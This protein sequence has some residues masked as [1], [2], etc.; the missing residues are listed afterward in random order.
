MKFGFW[1]GPILIS[2]ALA[3]ELIGWINSDIGNQLR[4]L[5]LILLAVGFLLWLTKIIVDNFEFYIGTEFN[6]IDRGDI[7]KVIKIAKKELK[8]SP[9]RNEIKSI[10]DIRN[11]IIVTQKRVYKFFGFKKKRVTGFYS[12]FPLKAEVPSLLDKEQISVRQFTNDHIASRNQR[13]ISLYLGGVA[14]KGFGFSIINCLKGVI[15]TEKRNGLEAV[16]TRPVT[17]VG[18]KLAKKAGFVPVDDTA[19]ENELDRIYKLML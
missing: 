1:F 19:N 3:L 5:G 17:E 2:I 7:N 14:T 8:Q 12:I 18:L 4:I 9:S 11:D 15:L 13:T 6:M 16:Y 10:L